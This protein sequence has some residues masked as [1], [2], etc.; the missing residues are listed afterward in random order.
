M[1]D[2][3]VH[4]C[5]HVAA[6]AWHVNTTQVKKEDDINL[7]NVYKLEY[8]SQPREENAYVTRRM[9]CGLCYAHER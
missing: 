4:K 2:I 9:R 1:S 5:V 3:F 6:H 8:A 7:Q